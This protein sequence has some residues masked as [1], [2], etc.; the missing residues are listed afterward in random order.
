M[1]EVSRLAAQELPGGL[2]R[3]VGNVEAGLLAKR[4][5][6]APGCAAGIS[7]AGHWS[8]LLRRLAGALVAAHALG[9]QQSVVHAGL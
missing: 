7:G 9:R 2:Q 5:R 6:L 1:G 4:R 8:S 3:V